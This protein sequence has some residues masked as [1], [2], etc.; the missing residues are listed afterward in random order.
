MASKSFSSRTMFGFPTDEIAMFIGSNMRF[1]D[2]PLALISGRYRDFETAC[3]SWLY[4]RPRFE[5]FVNF[6]TAK[7]PDLTLSETLLAIADE[8]M[9][10]RSANTTDRS[11]LWELN[12]RRERLRSCPRTNVH[13]RAACPA[14]SMTWFRCTSRGRKTSIL[15]LV[16]RAWRKRGTT[17]LI[18]RPAKRSFR[19]NTRLK[20]SQLCAFRR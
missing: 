5:F 12:W 6:K 20:V 1:D 17:S 10:R 14:K 7:V 11:E 9:S 18:A 4:S 19:S 8:V 15:P 13:L 3:K 2:C 16:R